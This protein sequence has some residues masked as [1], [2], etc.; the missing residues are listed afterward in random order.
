MAKVELPVAG[1]QAVVRQGIT[2]LPIL[3]IELFRAR[4]KRNP[5]VRK[6]SEIGNLDYL[7]GLSHTKVV[8]LNNEQV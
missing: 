6:S 7:K 3:V 1:L 4:G 5:P 8:C 2:P